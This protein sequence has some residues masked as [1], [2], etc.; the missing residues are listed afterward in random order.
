M[1]GRLVVIP[2]GSAKRPTPAP[3]AELY[4][5]PYFRSCLAWARSVVPDG[6]IR[7]LSARHG[8]VELTRELAP[9][10]VRWFGPGCIELAD[11]ELQA[12]ELQAREVAAVGGAEY[13]RICFALWGE[14]VRRVVP[15]GL[16]IGH[17]R[18]ELRERA[19]AWPALPGD[20]AAVHALRDP[21]A[22]AFPDV[23]RAADWRARRDAE[24]HE[25]WL[26][27]QLDAGGYLRPFASRAPV[28]CIDIGGAA[29]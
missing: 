13:V 1:L 23:E 26:R 4:T 28:L 5:G 16:G 25:R 18:R 21:D 14:R 8:L 15:A 22:H 2:C 29:R 19:G 6:Q 7:I 20:L 12:R 9:Y 10:D 3:A 17:Q 11:L 27:L 24:E